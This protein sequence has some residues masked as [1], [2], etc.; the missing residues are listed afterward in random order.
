MENSRPAS[1]DNVHKLEELQPIALR[2]HR[3]ECALPLFW[4]I[5]EGGSALPVKAEFITAKD[6]SFV[7]TLRVIGPK[8]NTHQEPAITSA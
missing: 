2:L 8:G 7:P 4:L 6:I 3:L 5:V 1:F